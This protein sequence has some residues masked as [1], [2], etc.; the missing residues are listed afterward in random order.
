MAEFPAK[1]SIQKGCIMLDPAP[2]RDVIHGQATFR[3]DF[4]QIP[5]AQRISQVPAYA[6][7]DDDIGEVSP[8]E[9]RWSRS[10]HR[11]TLT[12][13]PEPFATHPSEEQI[14]TALQQAEMAKC[15]LRLPECRPGFDP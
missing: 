3:H 14:V 9:C 4:F 2:D 5:I 12:K 13:H 7:H 6:K 10:A 1:P 8:T 15:A 11:I